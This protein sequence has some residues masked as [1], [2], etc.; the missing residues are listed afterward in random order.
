MLLSM[1]LLFPSKVLL[2]LRSPLFGLVSQAEY[3]G[4]YWVAGLA[5]FLELGN[6]PDV[7]ALLFIPEL[8]GIPPSSLTC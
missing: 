2:V 4:V 1:L 3:K 8:S 5:A 7:Q 6:L